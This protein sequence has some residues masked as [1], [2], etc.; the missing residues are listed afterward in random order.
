[1]FTPNQ[2]GTYQ[3]MTKRNLDGEEIYGDPASLPLSVVR[4]AAQ[5]EK[6][7]VRSDSSASRGQADQM[8]A[9]AKILTKLELKVDDIVH[10]NGL[11]LRVTGTHPRFT[12]FGV[13]DHHESDLEYVT[14]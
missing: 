7:S 6:T 8:A 10:V 3:R 2:I 4:L 11:T 5:S 12:A 13:F 9:E 1:M 14:P